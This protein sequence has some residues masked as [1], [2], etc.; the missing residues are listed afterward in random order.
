MCNRLLVRNQSLGSLVNEAQ[1]INM[2]RGAVGNQMLGTKVV[3]LDNT[4]HISA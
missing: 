2:E 1:V 3:S 4:A